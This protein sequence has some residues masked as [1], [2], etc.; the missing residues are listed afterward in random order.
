VSLSSPRAAVW[1][2]R[3]SV[4]LTP[5][6]SLKFDPIENAKDFILKIVTH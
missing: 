1:V 3:P 5:V 6:C 2:S 4:Y